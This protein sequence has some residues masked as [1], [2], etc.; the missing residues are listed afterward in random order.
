MGKLFLRA[1][2]SG[3]S[4]FVVEPRRGQAE[5]QAVRVH[6]DGPVR[7]L[8]R[9]IECRRRL[10]FAAVE[11][12]QLLLLRLTLLR[13]G[14]LV[15]ERREHAQLRV[16]LHPRSPASTLMLQIRTRTPRILWKGQS[17]C[18]PL[19]GHPLLA[20]PPIERRLARRMLSEARQ[21]DRDM[22]TPVLAVL[23]AFAIAFA[24]ALAAAIEQVAAAIAVAFVS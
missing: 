21:L 17:G 4:I 23:T 24:L 14:D 15:A 2:S 9:G 8:Q 7:W 19:D 22:L 13:G 18:G 6:V 16:R 10:V 5:A 12:V 1:T 20:P 3:R 11:Q